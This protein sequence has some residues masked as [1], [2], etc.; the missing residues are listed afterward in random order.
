MVKIIVSGSCYLQMNYSL[1]KLSVISQFEKCV[2]YFTFPIKAEI[3]GAQLSTQSSLK[4]FI[5]LYYFSLI[6]KEITGYL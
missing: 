3:L 4:C 2:L 6:E 1:C 5:G